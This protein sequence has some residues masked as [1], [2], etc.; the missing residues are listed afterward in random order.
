MFV[1]V[2]VLGAVAAWWI[3]A[4]TD[5]LVALD[6]DI[7]RFSLGGVTAD[8]H[9]PILASDGNLLV[10]VDFLRD[11]LEAPVYI[12]HGHGDQVFVVWTAPHMLIDLQVG[13]E[14]AWINDE[15]SELPAPTFKIDETDASSN[16]S[17]NSSSR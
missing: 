11:E 15:P 10:P 5:E 13:Q 1:S 6:T 2:L 7:M 16:A 12:E 8:E 14:Y 9:S 3:S 17:S 4:D